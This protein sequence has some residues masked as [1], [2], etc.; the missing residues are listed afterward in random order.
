[1]KEM[2]EEG[3]QPFSCMLYYN[4]KD[5]LRQKKFYHIQ[6]N[7]SRGSSPAGRTKNSPKICA[8]CQYY[9]STL[10]VILKT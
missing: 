8:I 4:G 9:F 6:G 10:G 1:L 5:C 2:L 3:W 7:L